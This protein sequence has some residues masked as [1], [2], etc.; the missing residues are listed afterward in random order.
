M[1]KRIRITLQ[2]IL[3]LMSFFGFNEAVLALR[4]RNTVY[5]NQFLVGTLSA[6]SMPTTSGTLFI[7]GDFLL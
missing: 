5:M 2:I 1:N 3:T 7:T 6:S 4:Y